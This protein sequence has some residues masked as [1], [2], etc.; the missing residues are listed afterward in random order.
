MGQLLW[1][2]Q[3]CQPPLGGWHPRV[4]EQPAQDGMQQTAAGLTKH[5]SIHWSEVL[6]LLH[7]GAGACTLRRQVARAP[8]EGWHLKP[9]SGNSRR[10]VTLSHRCAA[11]AA[12]HRDAGRFQIVCQDH[13]RQRAAEAEKR[14]E[15]EEGEAICQMFR[16]CRSLMQG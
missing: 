3:L 12:L 9:G 13:T 15:R 8:R 11:T 2:H 1:Q 10:L 6:H 4:R 14:R 5:S 7:L 16:V